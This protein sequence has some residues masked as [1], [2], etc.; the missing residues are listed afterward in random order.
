MKEDKYSYCG[1]KAGWFFPGH[2]LKFNVLVFTT[3]FSKQKFRL[4]N[5]LETDII[6]ANISCSYLIIHIVI[7]VMKMIQMKIKW[8]TMQFS[9]TMES[10]SSKLEWSRVVPKGIKEQLKKTSRHPVTENISRTVCSLTV[11]IS[12]TEWQY[13]C[14]KCQ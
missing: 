10:V 4:E 14:N 13:T 7:K 9:I 5:S 1:N 6:L 11:L 2:S 12:P 8:E 3:V